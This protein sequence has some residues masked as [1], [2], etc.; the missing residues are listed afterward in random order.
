MAKTRRRL[1]N[2]NARL[3][4]EV[5]RLQQALEVAGRYSFGAI[6]AKGLPGTISPYPNRP[7]PAIRKDPLGFWEMVEP[8]DPK[9][10]VVMAEDGAIYADAPAVAELNRIQAFFNESNDNQLFRQRYRLMQITATAETSPSQ[11]GES[12]G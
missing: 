5:A 11:K 6:M 12:S 4:A 8:S 3:K 10:Q 7:G 9:P 2:E 1:R